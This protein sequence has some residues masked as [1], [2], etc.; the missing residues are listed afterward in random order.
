MMMSVL[1]LAMVGPSGSVVSVSE[2]CW[3]HPYGKRSKMTQCD[4]T[5]HKR[6]AS[7]TASMKLYLLWPSWKRN[8]WHGVPLYGKDNPIEH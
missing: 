6:Q 1:L 2:C 7:M 5:P 4:D 3:Q 8:V